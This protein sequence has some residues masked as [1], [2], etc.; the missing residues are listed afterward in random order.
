MTLKHHMILLSLKRIVNPEERIGPI[1]KDKNDIDTNGFVLLFRNSLA[2]KNDCN[3][4]EPAS[5]DPTLFTAKQNSAYNSIGAA[6]RSI[7]PPSGTEEKLQNLS[8]S[9]AGKSFSLPQQRPL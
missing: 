5:I 1:Y 6:P 2:F 4:V 3:N 9:T 8:R 7:L